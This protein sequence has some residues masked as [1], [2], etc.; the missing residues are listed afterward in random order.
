M[1]FLAKNTIFSKTKIFKNESYRFEVSEDKYNYEKPKKFAKIFIIWIAWSIRTIFCT[2]PKNYQFLSMT[3]I[4]FWHL[5]FYK[6]KF[7]SVTENHINLKSLSHLLPSHNHIYFLYFYSIEKWYVHFFMPHVV[8]KMF[9]NMYKITPLFKN[10]IL[11][12]F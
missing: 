4:P 8:I 7:I 9:L 12:V 2:H 6:I 3:N 10:C 11:S 5:S 1:C